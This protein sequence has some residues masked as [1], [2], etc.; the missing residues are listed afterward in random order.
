M[1]FNIGINYIQFIDSCQD[2]STYPIFLKLRH[3]ASISRLM[4]L[5]SAVTICFLFHPHPKT[6]PSI[7]QSHHNFYAM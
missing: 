4:H 7:D 5:L 6:N 2:N 3:W 1:I